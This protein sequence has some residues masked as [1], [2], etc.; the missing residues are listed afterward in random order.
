MKFFVAGNPVPKQSFRKTKTGGY[1]D[2]RV[3]AWQEAIGW[4][5][6]AE[7]VQL[8][9][10]NVKVNLLF[11]LKDRRRRDSDNLSKAVLDALN[12]IAWVDDTQVTDLHILKSLSSTP[13]VAIE[14]WEV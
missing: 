13:G 1:T 9:T 4:K 6:K 11:L 14:I 10:G 12:G 7:G 8:L 3:T 5:A 2:P